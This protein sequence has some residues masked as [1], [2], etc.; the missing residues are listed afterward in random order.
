LTKW[1]SRAICLV[2]NQYFCVY[3]EFSLF[4]SFSQKQS[5]TRQVGLIR[6]FSAFVVKE[7][8]QYSA[9]TIKWAQRDF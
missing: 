6:E 9:L 4:E 7:N 5:I 8:A 1:L 3:F 2:E